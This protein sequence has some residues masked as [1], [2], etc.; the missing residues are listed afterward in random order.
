NV[1]PWR[2]DVHRVINHQRSRFMAAGQPSRKCQGELEVSRVAGIDLV[3]RAEPSACVILRRHYP[4]TII[5]LIL[6]LRDERDAPGT[7]QDA[8]GSPY[9]F[10]SP[11][12]N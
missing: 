10:F 9:I 7:K 3:E 5:R 6:N 4:L 2:H 8:D 11:S 1:G 12:Q